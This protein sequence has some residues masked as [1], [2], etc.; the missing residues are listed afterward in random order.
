[1]PFSSKNNGLVSPVWSTIH[2]ITQEPLLMKF[3]FLGTKGEELLLP[4]IKFHNIRK[5]RMICN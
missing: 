1:M 2:F 4:E 5:K 3:F